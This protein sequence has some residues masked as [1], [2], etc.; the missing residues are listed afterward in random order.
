VTNADLT[1]VGFVES[2]PFPGNL[3]LPQLEIDS[4]ALYRVEQRLQESE[5]LGVSQETIETEGSLPQ[6]D[7]VNKFVLG[8]GVLSF[9]PGISPPA[10]LLYPHYMVINFFF[11][12]SEDGGEFATFS[13]TPPQFLGGPVFE[14]AGCNAGPCNIVFANLLLN[15]LENSLIPT[16]LTI[17]IY[18]SAVIPLPPAALLF[19]SALAAVAAGARRRK[20]K[21]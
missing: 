21:A 4:P 17:S 2:E 5:E 15:N 18:N 14:I 3:V 12:E 1:L 10:G 13:E 11:D 20:A 19:G 16:G 7:Y 6:F 8:D 9:D